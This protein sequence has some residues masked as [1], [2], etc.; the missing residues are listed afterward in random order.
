[1]N[2]SVVAVL[3]GLVTILASL[4]GAA[5]GEAV[6]VDFENA[7]VGS[8]PPE[9]S[10]ALTN[11][12]K[13][14]LWVVERND[15]GNALVQKSDDPT[16]G[17][18]PLCIYDALS[19]RD[20]DVSVRVKPISGEKD[21]AG[22]IVWRYR[23]PNNY[24]VARANALEGNVVLYKVEGG[25]RSDL[26]PVGSGMF[27]YGKKVDVPSGT[28]STLRVDAKG[29]RFAVS[30]NG[31]HLFDV[32]DDTFREAGRVGLWTKADSVT[33]F[34]DLQIEPHDVASP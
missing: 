27:A 22:G 33:A 5:R 6:K 2:R 29:N 13:P 9:F 3:L 10:T 7:A 16:S 4:V 14:G 30:L 24:Y 21:R 25:K 12:G 11:G 20:V 19:A 31:Q 26:K 8:P 17:R 32:E 34:D 18:F 28:W 23:D 15:P 1:M